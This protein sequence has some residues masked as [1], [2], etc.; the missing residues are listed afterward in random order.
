[1]LYLCEL[2]PKQKETMKKLVLI[3]T[4]VILFA[5]CETNH[6]C[7]CKYTYWGFTGDLLSGSSHI[8]KSGETPCE[9]FEG[10]RGKC[11]SFEEKLSHKIIKNTKKFFIT[12]DLFYINCYNK[13]N[14]KYAYACVRLNL[15]DNT[16]RCPPFYQCAM[17]LM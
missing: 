10:K 1:M 12:I 15:C 8:F 3:I 13:I 11:V 17:L 4:L 6:S 2:K 7:E 14:K 9:Y 5:A 16:C